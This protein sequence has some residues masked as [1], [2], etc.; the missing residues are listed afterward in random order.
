MSAVRATS[1]HPHHAGNLAP[2]IAAVSPAPQPNTANYT[3]TPALKSSAAG[4]K[5][6][7]GM[8]EE[9]LCN[10]I[11]LAEKLGFVLHE[12]VHKVI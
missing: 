7:G 2:G 3:K 8:V 6:K 9:D 12:I 10:Q 11:S 4:E 1:L 5:W